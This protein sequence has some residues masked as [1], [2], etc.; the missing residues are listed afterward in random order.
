[1][2]TRRIAIGLVALILAACAPSLPPNRALV[3]DLRAL[4]G[5]YTGNMDE[6]SEHDRS[7]R[8]VLQP[9]GIFELVVSDPKG[10]RTGGTMTLLTDGTLAYQ[11]NEMRGAGLMA[12]GTGVVY[13]GDG[14]RAIVLT[15][16]D[17]STK[18]TVSRSLP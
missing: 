17:G 14:R 10:F 12:T 6:A 9:D 1:M 4:A 7:V 16:N 13:E 5:T 8:L 2:R 3:T 11:Y 15:Q 18:T